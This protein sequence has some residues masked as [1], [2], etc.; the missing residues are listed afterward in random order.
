MKLLL[1]KEENDAL[2]NTLE[3]ND[4]NVALLNRMI[5]Y[6]ISHFKNYTNALN[7]Q[8]NSFQN[9]FQLKLMNRNTYLF[10]FWN[11][12]NVPVNEL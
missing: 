7:L 2:F 9:S 5:N 3:N 1:P 11:D 10:K 4:I 12:N 6:K 8:P